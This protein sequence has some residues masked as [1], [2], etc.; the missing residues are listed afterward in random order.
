M[1]WSREQAGFVIDSGAGGVRGS[2]SSLAAIC[3][4]TVSKRQCEGCD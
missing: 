4:W 1:R 2:M 3:G